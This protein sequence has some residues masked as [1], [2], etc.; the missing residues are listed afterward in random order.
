[1]V[2]GYTISNE[3]EDEDK[4]PSNGIADGE[5]YCSSCG[6]AIKD[7][8]KYCP[9]CGT[10]QPVGDNEHRISSFT[11]DEVE[12]QNQIE[13]KKSLP[14]LKQYE[15]EKI[16][17]KNGTVVILLSIFLTP[18]GY[19]MVGK[20]GWALLNFFTFNY[21][22]LGPILVPIH[23]YKIMNDAEKELRESGVEGY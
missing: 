1:M 16:A 4:E 15:L 19:L 23:T 21:L 18:V 6:T 12:P 17:N 8:T 20:V 14:E 3:P 13:E 22:L 5:V 10:E 7:T 2:E 9:E 11:P